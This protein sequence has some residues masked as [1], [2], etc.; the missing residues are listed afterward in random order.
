MEGRESEGKEW[1]EREERDEGKGLE[2]LTADAA[3]LGHPNSATILCSL[4]RC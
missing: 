3:V 4:L 2:G 1:K